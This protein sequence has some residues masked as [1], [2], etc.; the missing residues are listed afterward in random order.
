MNEYLEN[1]RINKVFIRTYVLLHLKKK[2]PKA[3]HQKNKN[4]GQSI[5]YCV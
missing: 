1:L 4:T 5:K 2:S 3:N